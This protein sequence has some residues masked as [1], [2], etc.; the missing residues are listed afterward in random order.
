[1]LVSLATAEDAALCFARSPEE[2]VVAERTAAVLLTSEE[3]LQQAQAEGLTLRKSVN[4]THKTGYW[5]VNLNMSSRPKPYYAHV[6]RG[7][8]K[9]HLGS[10]VSAEGAALCIARAPHVRS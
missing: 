5:G 3:A 4:K 8:K 7:G 9:V 2:R 10:F 1:M 6:W